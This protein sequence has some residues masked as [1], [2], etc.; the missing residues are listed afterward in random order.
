M[1]A[2]YIIIGVLVGLCVDWAAFSKLTMIL[3]AFG[4]AGDEHL[5]RNTLFP[6]VVVSIVSS[7][8]FVIGL[9]LQPH[10]SALVIIAAAIFFMSS[11]YGLFLV[12]NGGG[13]E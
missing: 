1:T 11:L 13:R 10:S 3:G 9:R 2:I 6:R 4:Q 7:I 5:Y 8:A 12:M